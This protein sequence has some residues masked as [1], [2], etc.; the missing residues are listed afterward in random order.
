LQPENLIILK[1][2]NQGLKKIQAPETSMAKCCFR[3][4]VTVEVNP[5]YLKNRSGLDKL[6]ERGVIQL[7]DY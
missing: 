7:N 4:T 5:S 2:D 6:I 3:N 1:I